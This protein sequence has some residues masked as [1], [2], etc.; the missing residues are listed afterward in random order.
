MEN[1]QIK[2]SIT[3][4][5]REARTALNVNDYLM[6]KELHGVSLLDEQVNILLEEIKKSITH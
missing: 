6:V 2:V 3:D 1:L 5:E 4:G